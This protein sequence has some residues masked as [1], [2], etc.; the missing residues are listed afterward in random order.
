MTVEGDHMRMF[1]VVAVASLGSGG[2]YQVLH[3][4]YHER[5]AERGG[6]SF[7][8]GYVAG[9]G[10]LED[11]EPFPIV[12][13][14]VAAGAWGVRGAGAIGAMFMA[15]VSDATRFFVRPLLACLVIG[16][17]ERTDGREDLWFGVGAEADLG[18]AFE[19]FDDDTF[20]ELGLRGGGDLSYTGNGSGGFVG[21]FLGWAW[22]V[23]GGD[24]LS[25]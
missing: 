2:C 4:G 11:D 3:V 24:L 14:E 20:I 15:D 22:G 21:I 1:G 19:A 7:E 16:A 10:P 9:L 5:F 23:D 12:K 6:R 18:V 13:A 25:H 8:A 17:E